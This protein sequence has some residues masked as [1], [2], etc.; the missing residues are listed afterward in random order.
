M[1]DA[2]EEALAQGGEDGGAGFVGDHV[3][4]FPRVGL[5]VVEEFFDVVRGVGVVP[6]GEVGGRRPNISSGGCGGRGRPGIRKS[7]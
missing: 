1:F 6:A 5:D 2:G 4:E 3:V 7:G